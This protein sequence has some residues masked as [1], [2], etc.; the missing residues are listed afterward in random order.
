MIVGCCA[1]YCDAD[2]SRPCARCEYAVPLYKAVVRGRF[3]QAL[4]DRPAREDAAVRHG[5]AAPSVPSEEA[6]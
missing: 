6:A 4:P 5:A 3:I 1:P 2:A